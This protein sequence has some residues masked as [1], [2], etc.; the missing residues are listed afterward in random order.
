MRPGAAAA[1]LFLILPAASACTTSDDHPVPPV[2]F[3][4]SASDDT[5]VQMPD[6]PEPS[7]VTAPP[8]GGPAASQAA[9]PDG[10]TMAP[11]AGAGATASA[12]TAD[13]AP[14]SSPA[15]AS[16]RFTPVIGAPI[17]VVRPLSSQ[18]A[19]AA[20]A[21]GIAIRTSTDTRTDNILRGYFSASSNGKQTVVVYVWDVLDNAGNRV[22]RIQGQETVEGRTKGDPWSAVPASIM[23]T[24]ADKTI[25][26]YAAWKASSKS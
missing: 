17:E 10:S 14:A 3:Q 12:A 16:I 25:A 21:Q 7:P 26:S 24:I 15:V 23:Q 22:D 13:A 9:L 6:A 2:G 4:S 5:I 18:L 8:Q 11:A 20:R 1:A 19:A